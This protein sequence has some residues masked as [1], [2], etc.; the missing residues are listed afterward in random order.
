MERAAEK[1]PVRVTI[2]SRPYVVRTADDP[3][4]VEALASS[5]NDLMLSIAA[6]SPSADSTHIAV[7]ACLHLADRLRTMEHDFASLKE[8]VNRKSGEFAAL[9]DQ[10]VPAPEEEAR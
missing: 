4:Q 6:R 9:L 8:R 1:K 3:R 10:L 5:V 7:L 2:L